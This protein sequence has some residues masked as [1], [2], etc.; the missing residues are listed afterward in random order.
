[1]EPHR[2]W[3]VFKNKFPTTV[4]AEELN[5]YQL[6][7]IQRKTFTNAFELFDK[8][9]TGLLLVSDF[10]ALFRSIGQNPTEADLKRIA[11]SFSGNRQEDVA[12]FDLEAFLSVCESPELKD[13]TKP[14]AILEVFR[15]FDKDA[16][17][18]LTI[19]Q[20]RTILQLY[21]ERLPQAIAN[22]LMDYIVN[23]C[24]KEKT[25]LINYETIVRSLYS[26]D[27]GVTW[28]TD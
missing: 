9:K 2:S 5:R 7:D 18:T 1:M 19:P 24:D 28:A 14:E 13:P 23:T 26:K 6:S 17:Q 20:L 15:Q 3:G 25:G 10:P 8:D 11:V 27:P 21:G 4:M 22:D 16:S 12:T